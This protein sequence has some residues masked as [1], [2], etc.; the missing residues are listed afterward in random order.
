VLIPAWFFLLTAAITFPWW[1]HAGY[2][3]MLDSVWGPHQAINWSSPDPTIAWQ[4]IVHVLTAVL[5]GGA[6]EK[7]VWSVILFVIGL[8]GY[9][10]AKRLLPPVWAWTSAS[11]YLLN[12][13]VYERLTSGQWIV[14]AGYAALPISVGLA[15]DILY[16][17]GRRGAY[18]WLVVFALYPLISEHFAYMN[19][20]LCAALLLIYCLNDRP[21]WLLRRSTLWWGIGLG[22]ATMG[23]NLVWLMSRSAGH[24]G[25][26]TSLDFT[27]FRTAADP[28]VGV[29]GNVLGLYGFWH[30]AAFIEPKDLLGTVWLAIAG[31]ILVLSLAGAIRAIRRHNVL[32]QTL[33]VA[34]PVAAVIAVGY[35]SSE[36]RPLTNFFM[37][38]LPGFRGLRDSEKL[39]GVMALGYAVLAPF[40]AQG[41]IGLLPL[42]RVIRFAPPILLTAFAA[43]SVTGIWAD[44]GGQIPMTSYPAGW[45]TVRT[46]LNRVP[47]KTVVI[48]PWHEYLNLDFT[49]SYVAQ[50]AAVFFTNPLLSSDELDN[51]LV[52]RPDNQSDRLM[53]EFTD[54]QI[55]AASWV[56][57]LKQEGAS[58]IVLEKTDDGPSYAPKLSGARLRTE[59]QDKTI[60]LY[61]LP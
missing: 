13:F 58:Y 1:T 55:S 8:A 61:S 5:P 45:Y 49:G 25:S 36:T 53:L 22:V 9:F 7:L 26:F 32:A 35:S 2:I 24:F 10:L 12:P 39:V 4:I 41:L 16:T 60:A 54:G 50:P 15:T 14:L 28:H 56:S 17:K 29:W 40:G 51:I 3:W 46:I 18:R 21:R 31:I 43:L 33:V 30:G 20:F 27:T 48:L 23:A 38:Y 52:A 44:I 59:F 11:L 6:A 47:D 37:Q 57:A 34:I 42:P 19:V